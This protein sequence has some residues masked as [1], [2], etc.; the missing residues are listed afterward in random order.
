MMMSTF[1]DPT[2]L[3]IDLVLD[4]TSSMPGV[5]NGSLRRYSPEEEHHS[6]VLATARDIRE[7]KNVDA[8][9]QCWLASRATCMKLVSQDEIFWRAG[10]AREIIGEKFDCLYYTTAA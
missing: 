3:K 1:K 9:R 7:G 2:P 5:H 10:Q 8:W 6:F 4:E